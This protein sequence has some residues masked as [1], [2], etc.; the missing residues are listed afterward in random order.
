EPRLLHD[1]RPSL[2]IGSSLVAPR[3]GAWR[4]TS[5]SLP[6]LLKLRLRLRWIDPVLVTQLYRNFLAEQS[7]K[8]HRL[9]SSIQI[10]SIGSSE[11][12]RGTFEGG[13]IKRKK[14]NEKAC[15]TARGYGRACPDPRRFYP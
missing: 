15:D 7:L 4:A 3:L 2:G 14:F 11:D 12:G 10:L 8:K 1:P 9:T 13:T 5:L 6:A